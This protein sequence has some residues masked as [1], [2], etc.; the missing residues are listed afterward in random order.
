MP[1]LFGTRAS[2]VVDVSLSVFVLMPL[3]LFVAIRRA[4]NR[5]H[6]GHQRMQI[7][8]FVTMTVAVVLLE[9]DIRLA[10]GTSAIAGRA[11]SL[12]SDVIRVVLLAHIGVAVA[13]WLGWLSLL[14]VSRRRFE[15]VLPG[16]FSR[17]HRRLGLAV[18]AGNIVNAVSGTLLYVVTFV[19]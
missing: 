1:G 2:L 17:R 6:R 9:V 3:L 14:V 4:R 16:V 12:S 13:T 11:I 7:A 19:S 10:G 5:D 18:W 8:L 15:S